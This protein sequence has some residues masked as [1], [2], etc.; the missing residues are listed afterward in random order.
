MTTISLFDDALPPPGQSIDSIYRSIQEVYLNYSY[1]WVIGYSGGK[2]STTV[3][4]M[5][6]YALLELRP[7]QRTKPVYVI[8]SDTLVET[9]AIVGY[10]DDT[11]RRINAV[12]RRENMP[13]HAQK[14]VPQLEDTFWV[15]LIGKGYPAPTSIFRWC[16]DRLKIKPSNRFILS[17]VA[18]HGEV[19]LSLGIR[20]GE[21]ATRD[22]VIN[23]HRVTGHTLARHGQLPGAWVYMPIENF[24]ADD[25]WRYLIQVESPWGNDNRKLAALYRSA[26]SGECPLVIDT[27]T[28]SC[29]NSRFGCWTCTVVARDRSME[30]MIDAGEEWMVPLLNFRDWLA[31]TQDPEVKP[32]QREYKSRTGQIKISEGGKLRYRTYTLEFSRQMLRRLLETQAEVQEYNAGYVLI[33][34]DELREIR[35]IWLTER[36]DWEDSVPQIFREA[37]GRNLQFEVN[38]VS[39]PGRVEAEL[40]EQV[41]ERHDVPLKLMQKLLDAEWQHFGMRRRNTIHSTI[42]RIYRE[43][44]RSLEEVQAAM[45]LD[46]QTAGDV[47]EP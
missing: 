33:S 11:M 27:N 26:Q 20:Q 19:I 42:E 23:M 5:V 34:E 17:K 2:D 1:P 36:Q 14:L 12:A 18:E 41:A 13:F 10:I 4:Q 7:E 25:V 38:D 46:M 3:L 28:A 45:D 21:S 31:S 9:P 30:A 43:D 35:R 24:S 22:Q 47:E 29:G 37:T 15:N 32:Q 44:W 8:S 16:T 40:L 39:A 6:W